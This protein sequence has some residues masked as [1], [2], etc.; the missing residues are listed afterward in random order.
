MRRR[1]L[2]AACHGEG[3]DDMTEGWVLAILVVLLGLLVLVCIVDNA[4]IS[5]GDEKRHRRGNGSPSRPQ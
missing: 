3:G 5:R 1:R 4:S 2:G